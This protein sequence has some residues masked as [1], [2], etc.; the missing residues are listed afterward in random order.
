MSV[1]KCDIIICIWNQK[2]LTRDCLESIQKHTRFPFHLILIDNASED[3]TRSYLE[4]VRDRSG[5]EVTIIRNEENLGNTKA[6]NQGL[7]AAT[8]KYICNLDNDTLVTEG[9][10]TGL[11]EALETEPEVGMAVP[12]GRGTM[13]PK[14]E[15]LEAVE[16]CGQALAERRGSLM[17]LPAVDCFCVVFKK[18]MVDEIGYWDEIYSPGYYDDTDYSCRARQAGYKAVCALGT[19]V[20]HRTSGSFKKNKRREEIFN[21]NKKIFHSRYGVPQRIVFVV[22]RHDP[23][24]YPKIKEDVYSFAKRGHWVWVIR[25]KS[26][27]SFEFVLHSHIKQ[28]V[29][30]DFCF[31][32]RAFFRILAKQK[33]RFNYVYTTSRSLKFVLNIFQLVHRSRIRLFSGSSRDLQYKAHFLTD[34]AAGLL[35]DAPKGSVLDLGCGRGLLSKKIHDMGFAVTA[36]DMKRDRFKHLDVIQ[37]QNVNLDQPLPFDD[38]S[39]DYIFFLEVV[40][41]LKNPYQVVK[42]IS[43]I[44]KPE[45]ILILST[46]NI[47]NLRSRLRFLTEGGFDFFR[48]PVLD[49][50]K[51]YPN[52][53]ENMHI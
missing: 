23:Q 36:A 10:L 15:T 12:A 20:Y 26:L 29:Y 27:P 2:E 42:E 22:D 13:M 16:H 52:N 37:F 5:M 43:R 18:K 41:H 51:L 28:F 53:L 30:P 38:D 7:K 1:D 9:W 46:P 50:A 21:R 17:E 45:G 4:E 47:L 48:E 34:T 24:Q 25:K 40:E 19:Y 49:L 32:L 8:N 44:L 11:I 31:R 39:F 14:E 35:T 6:V 33:K 3:E